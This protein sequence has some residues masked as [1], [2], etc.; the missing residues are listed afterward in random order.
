MVLLY[1][2]GN[3]DAVMPFGFGFAFRTSEHRRLMRFQYCAF[4]ADRSKL[5]NIVHTAFVPERQQPCDCITL[6]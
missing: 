1:W 6:S 3:G 4:L 2:N 5:Y